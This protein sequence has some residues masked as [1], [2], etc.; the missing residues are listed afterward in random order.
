[1]PVLPAWAENLGSI[2]LLLAVVAIVLMRLPPVQG[3]DHSAAFRRRR[4]FNWL[5]L[6]LTYAFLYMARYNLSVSKA[7]F[8]EMPNSLGH[9][10]MGNDDF[11]WI[12]GVGTAVYGVSF[13]INGPL[14]DRFGGKF[15]IITGATGAAVMNLALGACAWCSSAK[16]RAT[17]VKPPRFMPSW[18]TTS[19]SSSRCSTRPI[20][21]SR[22]SA[23]SRS[24]R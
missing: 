9:P 14:T 19:A 23:R 11:G 4:V 10:M 8:G 16:V 17:V 21:T 3:V 18:R 15:A 6:G 1:M 7:K 12:F 13:L 2:S 20:C 24:S 5:P 22:P